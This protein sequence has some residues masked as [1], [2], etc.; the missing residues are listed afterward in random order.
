MPPVPAVLWE[1]PVRPAPPAS[2]SP[3]ELLEHGVRFGAYPDDD[4]NGT[5]ER[6]RHALTAEFDAEADGG[7]LV[8]SHRREAGIQCRVIFGDIP[9]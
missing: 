1:V 6:V 2:G 4:L 7:G 3:A 9:Q 8:V 5:E